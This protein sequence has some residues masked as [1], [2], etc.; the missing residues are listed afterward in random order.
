MDRS[1]VEQLQLLIHDKLS[2]FTAV[3]LHNENGTCVHAEVNISF[4]KEEELDA[5]IDSLQKM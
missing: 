5:A 2:G 3:V 4:R 1:K